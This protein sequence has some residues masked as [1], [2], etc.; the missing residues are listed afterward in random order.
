M[1]F[2]F[3]GVISDSFAVAFEVEKMMCP[4]TSEENYR[5]A[6]EG[7]I[8]DWNWEGSEHTDACR[9][10][11]DFFS[12]YLPKMRTSVH[13]FPGM[14]DVIKNL[15]SSYELIIVSSTLSGIIL[16]F[17]RKFGLD[18][19]FKE[20]MGNDVHTSKTEKIKMIFEKYKT[21]AKNCV[22]VTDTLGDIMEAKKAGVGAIGVSWGFNT[23]E[24]LANGNPFR[25][26]SCP[27]ELLSAT[28]EYFE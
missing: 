13:P 9:H 17:T 1:L 5:K 20:I 19:I 2:D 7:N 26:V 11:M 25:V 14:Q 10:D 3:D 22:F 8:H 6:Y 24:T 16:E 21:S 15:S 18:G 4:N 28:K 12:I 23:R 27:E